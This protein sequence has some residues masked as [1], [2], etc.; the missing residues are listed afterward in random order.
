M[1][2]AEPGLHLRLKRVQRQIEAQ[3]R[4][5]GPI[6]QL[7]GEALAR[8][9]REEA[10]AAFDRYAEAIDAHF[11]LEEEFFFP[12]LHGLDPEITSALDGLTRDHERFAGRVRAMGARLRSEPLDRCGKEL[13]EFAAELRAH[14]LREEQIVASLGAGG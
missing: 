12:A 3:H 13:D 5:L 1:N 8:G 6:F 7:L 10:R 11:A 14:E 9:V 4:H 2:S